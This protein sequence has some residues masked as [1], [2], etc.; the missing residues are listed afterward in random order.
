MVGMRRREFVTLLGS[1]A[2]AFLS[3]SIGL[4]KASNFWPAIEP[5]G[6][7]PTTYWPDLTGLF[8]WDASTELA[9]TFQQS[10]AR[11]RCKFMFAAIRR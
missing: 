2:A 1:A 4:R 8:L 5:S 3:Q 9:G 7:P 10:L 6:L 11:Q